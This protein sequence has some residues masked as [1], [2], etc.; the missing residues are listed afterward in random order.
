MIYLHKLFPF[1]LHEGSSSLP[2]CT[3]EGVDGS[4][5][6]GGEGV[7][8]GGA[9]VVED[10]ANRPDHHRPRLRAGGVELSA[11]GDG[12]AGDRSVLWQL[13]YTP[14]FIYNLNN[15]DLFC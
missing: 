5:G 4:A 8:G 12:L 10:R 14:H 13:G 15:W 11:G 6:V 2:V 1:I 7:D 9:L 3:G